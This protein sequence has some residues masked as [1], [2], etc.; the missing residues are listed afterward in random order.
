MNAS[1]G[2]GAVVYLLPKWPK[3]K[4]PLSQ[5]PPPPLPSCSCF[6]FMQKEFL[7]ISRCSKLSACHSQGVTV[8]ALFPIAFSFNDISTDLSCSFYPLWRGNTAFSQGQR[9]KGKVNIVPYQILQTQYLEKVLLHPCL[10]DESVPQGERSWFP[11]P[12]WSILYCEHMTLISS[13]APIFS[14]IGEWSHSIF[15]SENSQLCCVLER[16]CLMKLQL[17]KLCNVC[18]VLGGKMEKINKKANTPPHVASPFSSSWCLCHGITWQLL[19]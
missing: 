19:F 14:W 8:A 5:H 4:V 16:S 1:F 15:A 13:S 10:K 6:V 17:L 2:A 12:P 7:I 3:M 9:S 18:W 11:T